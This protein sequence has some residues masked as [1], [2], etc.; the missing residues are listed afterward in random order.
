MVGISFAR[1]AKASIADD[2]N[3]PGRLVDQQN[4]SISSVRNETRVPGG[5]D[6]NDGNKQGGEIQS[7]LSP[8]IRKKKGTKTRAKPPEKDQ[9]RR[10]D[11]LG[12]VG[13]AQAL[14]TSA[15]RSV[16]SGPSSFTL[17]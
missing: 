5:G 13:A 10:D 3:E 16:L 1:K 4:P 17:C 12:L 15:W 7:L 8:K 9:T 6:S 14:L 11:D 2:A